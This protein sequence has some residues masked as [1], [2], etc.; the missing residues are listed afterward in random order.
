MERIKDRKVVCAISGGIDSSVAAALLKESGFQVSGAFMRLW[1]GS[2]KGE[3]ARA[4]RIAASLEIPF[5]VFNFEKEF[6]KKVVDNFLNE[7]QQGRTPNPCVVCNKE[8]KFGL[9]LEKALALGAEYLATG[10]YARLEKK[11]GK[12]QLW[13]G[14]DKT[15]D[16]SYFLWSLGQKQLKNI[17]FP[18]GGYTKKQVRGLAGKFAL[19]V[20]NIPESQEI[21]FI[22]KSLN[23]FLASHL[24]PKPGQIID[25]EGKT[26]GRHQGLVFYTIGQRKGLDLPG[27]PFYVVKKNLK[28]N[29]LVVA[30]LLKKS[31]LYRQEL[32]A[33]KVNWISGQS[34]KLPLRIKA[35]IRYQ[36][37]AV[38]AELTKKNRDY[39]LSFS[40]P[41]RAITAG[42][43]VVFY[44]LCRSKAKA[45]Q[46]KNC[47]GGGI[48]V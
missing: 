2:A 8:I 44:S 24:R 43:S 14:R 3:L 13:R 12:I 11:G 45:D 20:L 36:H 4:R 25:L 29:T 18:L 32:I 30:H 22:Q 17:L 7:Y 6:K 10:H 31:S 33:K 1:P 23:H 46:E 27:G 39:Y 40:K 35:Q 5:R 9:L 48:I 34:P 15:K 28:E 26:I 16:Q 19:P 41:Q 38:T 37:Q 21:C 42:Q 47:L